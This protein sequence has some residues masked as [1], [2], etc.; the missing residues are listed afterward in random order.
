MTEDTNNH[1]CAYQVRGLRCKYPGAIS[2][3]ILGGGPWYCRIHI[4]E[5]GNAIAWQCLEQSQRDRPEPVAED[6]TWLDEHFPMQPQETR[7]EYNLRCRAKALG[8]G[9]GPST[10]KGFRVKPVLS[11][12][13]GP[14]AIR[15]PGEDMVEL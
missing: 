5:Q 9:L 7:Q 4:R 15:E 14:V 3:G 10:L 12:A 8:A 11:L 6:R 1:D 2:P 13:N